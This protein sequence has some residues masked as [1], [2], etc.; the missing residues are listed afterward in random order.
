MTAVQTVTGEEII[1]VDGIAGSRDEVLEVATKLIGRV[2]KALGD[3]TSE[4]AQQ[5]AMA[6]ISAE[7]SL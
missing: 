1:T 6:S 5:F 3:D 2:R 7:R 4:S